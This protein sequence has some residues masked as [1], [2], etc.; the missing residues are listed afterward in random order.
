MKAC[1]QSFSTAP[2]FGLPPQIAVILT[3]GG[4]GL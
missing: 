2:H 3:G 4:I 1:E